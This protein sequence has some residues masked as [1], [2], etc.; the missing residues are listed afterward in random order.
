M[1][2]CS[3]TMILNNE[4]LSLF[5][6][7]IPLLH[8]Q[9]EVLRSV[10]SFYA[11]NRLTASSVCVQ[12][13]KRKEVHYHLILPVHPPP[14]IPSFCS[15]SSHSRLLAFDS[16]ASTN[17]QDSL[18]YSMRSNVSVTSSGVNPN[19]FSRFTASSTSSLCKGEMICRFNSSHT[20][21]IKSFLRDALCDRKCDDSAVKSCWFL[22]CF[23]RFPKKAGNFVMI[24]DP[25]A[26][27]HVRRIDVLSDGSNP[28]FYTIT[29][30]KKRSSH[31][32]W[33]WHCW[34]SQHRK[35]NQPRP[36]SLRASFRPC[37]AC[38]WSTADSSL[39]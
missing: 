16:F 15:S 36:P 9:L 4:T 7:R 21:K 31:L 25:A 34:S 27:E 30:W 26:R 1:K 6:I 18:C 24:N 3:S 2:V 23:D 35:A 20:S 39:R 17:R 32:F 33:E 5:L 13:D 28:Q 10:A 14:A 11:L 8:P 38:W 37:N 19:S 12:H 29:K 22:R